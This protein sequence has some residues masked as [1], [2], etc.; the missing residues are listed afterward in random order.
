MIILVETKD[1]KI[2]LY[3]KSVPIRFDSTNSLR[4]V[5]EQSRMAR[6][7]CSTQSDARPAEYE[8]QAPSLTYLIRRIAMN[9]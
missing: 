1:H 5:S 3:G 8:T 7:R 6:P 4:T 2:R 9:I